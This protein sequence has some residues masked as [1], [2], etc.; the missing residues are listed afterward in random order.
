[1]KNRVITVTGHRDV[2]GTESKSNNVPAYIGRAIMDLMESLCDEGYSSVEFNIGMAV[3]ADQIVAEFLRKANVPY[4]AYIPCI[5]QEK[6]WPKDVQ[7]Y[8]NEVL[9]PNAKTRTLVHNGPYNYICMQMRNEL[10]VDNCDEVFAVYRGDV[11]GTSFTGG[12]GKCIK[13]ALAEG[14]KV[15]VFNPDTFETFVIGGANE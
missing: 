6:R 8:Y 9:I 4:N 3:G 14:K 5:G 12:T 1:M 10:M 13:Y 11:S 7:E 2:Y 15:T